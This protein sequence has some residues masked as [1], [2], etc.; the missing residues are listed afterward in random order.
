MTIVAGYVPT[1][2][3]AAA[4]DYAIAEAK[5]SGSLLV[6][7]N[8]SRGTTLVDR[9][10]A[11]PEE[12]DDVEERLAS[13]GLDH[14]V[15]QPVRGQDPADEVLDAAERHNAELI[16]IGIRS[17]RPWAN[18]SWAALLSASFLK[19]LAR[20]WRSKQAGEW[21][22]HIGGRIA[23]A[24]SSTARPRLGPFQH[25]HSQNRLHCLRTIQSLLKGERT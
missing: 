2:E 18:S 25:V 22:D 7:V 9:N 17:A 16:V 21:T 24:A 3:G 5:K 10:Y 6:V 13:G 8:S 14:M 20:S 23:S 11:S 1:Q 12:V 4:L 15:L 19:P